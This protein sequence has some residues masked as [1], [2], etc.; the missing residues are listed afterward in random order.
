MQIGFALA[1]HGLPTLQS[2]FYEYSLHVTG[3]DQRKQNKWK[4]N[5]LKNHE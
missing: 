3:S 1:V 2:L 4:R 5:S